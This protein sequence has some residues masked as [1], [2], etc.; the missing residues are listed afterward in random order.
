MS[1]LYPLGLLGLIGI[2][3]LV[4]VYVIKSKYAE[5]TVASTYLWTLSERFLKRKRPVS[6]LSGIISL[7]LQCLAVLLISLVIARPIITVPN[8]A[9]EYCFIV[10]ASGSMNVVRDGKTRF[11][12]GK[13][14]IE[15]IVDASS[16][17]SL[18]SLIFVGDITSQV[19][20][21]SN[22]KKEVKEYLAELEAGFV[23]ADYS[24]AV[25][26]AA[27]YFSENPAL[28]TYLVTDTDY[29]SADNIRVINVSGGEEN[30][31]I[32]NIAWDIS[33]GELTVSGTVISYGKSGDFKVHVFANGNEAAIAEA[34]VKANEGERVP[35]TAKAK[36]KAFDSLS[37]ILSGDDGLPIDNRRVIYDIESEE[38]HSI[39]LV[40]ETPFFWSSALSSLGHTK[41]TVM[42]PEEYNSQINGF[43]LY[44]FDCCTP[45]AAPDD[46]AVWYIDPQGSVPD[47]GFSVQGE[48]LL[49]RGEEIEMTS[50]TSSAARAMTAGLEG[51]GIEIIEYM[52]CSLYRSFTTLFSYAGAPLV[53]AGVGPGGHREVVFAFD[54][55]NSN[56]PLTVD[57]IML[58]DNL[59]RYSFPDVIEKTDYFAGDEAS[60][61]VVA[62]CSSIRVEA[63]SGAVTYLSVDTALT[64]FKLT[65]AGSYRITVTVSKI[66]TTYYIY[67]ALPE[68]ESDPVQT[69]DYIGFSGVAEE[70]GFDGSFDPV[71]I[72][73]ILIAIIFIA[74]WTVYCYEKY[75]L[76]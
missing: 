37:L 22:S 69:L 14:E 65:E 54:L 27:E 16:D 68:G 42:K 58:T 18:Y 25:T 29:E 36:L 57:F 62:N 3:I 46:G 35:F 41:I 66:P 26:K 55:H 19:L 44:I 60:V 20:D 13:E 12:Y 63:P 30:A 21:R 72:L 10:D 8:S 28:I 73:F 1:F 4:L 75:Q 34:Q 59:M 2:P 70:G 67:S 51:T 38:S 40:S 6:M 43:G 9:N 39:L 50:S 71:Y 31:A 11:E 15:K 32:S 61:N 56:L 5:Q 17:G 48:V 45:A 7:I 33:G 52:R 47:T 49:S 64:S 23:S 24:E 76:R 74:D 53:F